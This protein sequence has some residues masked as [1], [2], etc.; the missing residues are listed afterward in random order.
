MPSKRALLPQLLR[1]EILWGPAASGV[2]LVSSRRSRGES[3]GQGFHGG[4]GGRGLAALLASLDGSQ[5]SQ[6][7]GRICRA[8]AQGFAAGFGDQCARRAGERRRNHRFRVRSEVVK[9][10]VIH[11]NL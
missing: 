1:M 8:P 7:I 10:R 5:R 2:E 9:I 6:G 4:T 11:L 3:A